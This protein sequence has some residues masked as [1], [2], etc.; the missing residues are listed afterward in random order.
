MKLSRTFKVLFLL[1]VN[2]ELIVSKPTRYGGLGSSI[3]ILPAYSVFAQHMVNQ[4]A[5]N[6]AVNSGSSSYL[7]DSGNWA[8]P[9]VANVIHGNPMPRAPSS[10][11]KLLKA[12]SDEIS[13]QK[14]LAYDDES[15][16]E[17]GYASFKYGD[18]GMA[19]VY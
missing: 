8:N 2:V 11:D 18:D 6:Q 5:Q 14:D 12:E 17:N 15:D 3:Y 13:Y 7:T 19:M 1:C 16:K 4:R 10:Y 9:N